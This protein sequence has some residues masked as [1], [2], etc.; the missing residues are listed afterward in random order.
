MAG[1]SFASSSRELTCHSRTQMHNF[2]APDLERLY[3]ESY[4][5]RMVQWRLLG[6][7]DKTRNIKTITAGIGRSITSVLEVGC[8]TGAVLRNLAACNFA[9]QFVGIE[10]GDSNRA[11]PKNTETSGENI[12]TH[13]YDGKHI[14]Y[15][16]KS[17]DFVYATHVLEHVTDERGFLHEMERVTRRYVY[18]EVP[19]ELH[20]RTNFRA[21]QET[22]SIGH[23]NS[24]TPESFALTLETSGLTIRQLKT[25]DHSYAVQRFNSSAPRALLTTTLR[26]TLLVAS[27]TLASRVF[28]FHCG[29]LCEKGQ[30]LHL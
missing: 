26:R 20:M 12:Y 10:I 3:S 19:C 21:L 14:P 23:I 11:Q 24:Y 30:R 25:F 8:G 22:L 18:V 29:A 2:I 9:S 15:E 5:E 4:D 16:D 7:E 1:C 28:T 6:A 13:G 27:P 17:F